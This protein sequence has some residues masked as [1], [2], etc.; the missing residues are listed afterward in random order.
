MRV[1]VGDFFESLVIYMI[2]SCQINGKN[3]YIVDV[4]NEVLIPWVVERNKL[5]SA[6]NL[7]TFDT[8]TDTRHAFLMQAGKDAG[9]HDF[10][11]I[12]S[13]RMRYL[14]SLNRDDIESVKS[15]VRILYNDE[16]IVAALEKDIINKA[17]VEC[18]ESQGG[19]PINMGD[20]YEDRDNKPNLYI[21]QTDDLYD[22][23]G[24]NLFEVSMWEDEF[25]NKVFERYSDMIGRKISV[26]DFI[27]E[28]YI[29]DIDLD[30]FRNLSVVN[31]KNDSYIK[32]LFK[33]AT[34]ITVAK[35]F[36]YVKFLNKDNIEPQEILMIVM[37]KIK[38]F[39]E[40]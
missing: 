5:I 33:N 26:D 34:A 14:D 3:I 35:E 9:N 28:N 18:Y 21:P 6:P 36:E 30:C 1:V 11:T 38:S 20:Y 16:H 25:L 10:D 32:K 27:K 22:T 8:H 40:N 29:L 24:N 19:Y 17:L 2:N 13:I 15:A 31:P 4:H 23:N 12:F 37:D 7:I 39:L